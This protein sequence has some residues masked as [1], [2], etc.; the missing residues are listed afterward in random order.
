MSDVATRVREASEAGLAQACWRQWRSIKGEH[1]LTRDERPARS[2]IDPEALI[3]AS[4]ASRRVE[5]RLDESILWWLPR[6]SR[7]LSVQRFKTLARDFPLES[8]DDI[9]WF[10]NLAVG[11]GD[12]RWTSLAAE[13]HPTP[14]AFGRA[15]FPRQEKG[16]I[17]LELLEP[18]TLM[19]RLRA[20]FG[21]GAKADLLTFLLGV[22]AHRGRSDAW[23]EGAPIAEALAYSK[24][25]VRRATHDMTL[26]GLIEVSRDRSPDLAVDREAWARLLQR[27]HSDSALSVAETHRA[28]DQ[29]PGWCFWSQTFA[30]L[31]LCARWGT[32]VREGSA[33]PTVA[34][35]WA[36]DIVEAHRSLFHRNRWPR[37]ALEVHPGERLLEP[38]EAMVL[39]VVEWVHE[40]L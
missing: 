5:R 12:A 14:Q 28:A 17:A 13:G 4:L 15:R 35:S 33:P 26:A 24:V 3:L 18:A 39:N 38:F 36:R 31:G 19:L 23:V 10:A 27:T 22:A 11:S 29:L 6:G 16:P 34:A 20:G 21:V 7:L 30:L 9:T 32:R 8:Q 2:I 25:S 40:H 1:H 37:I